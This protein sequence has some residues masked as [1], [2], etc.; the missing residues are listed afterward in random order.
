MNQSG[1]EQLLQMKF[2]APLRK[3]GVRGMF[4]RNSKV[5]MNTPLNF[6]TWESFHYAFASW[7]RRGAARS[8]FFGE[9][10]ILALCLLLPAMFPTTSNAQQ[11]IPVGDPIETY[12]RFL[13]SDSTSSQH[14]RPINHHTPQTSPAGDHPWANHSFFSPVNDHAGFSYHFYQPET[15]FTYNNHFAHGWNDGAMW[16]G[17]GV[18]YRIRSGISL[19]YKNFDLSVRP[20]FGRSLNYDFELSGMRSWPYALSEFAMPL[21]RIDNPVRFGDEPF[22]WFHPGQSSLTYSDYGFKAGISTENIWSGP[23]MHNPLILSNNAPGFF[24]FRLGTD[25]PYRTTVGDFEGKLFWGGLRESDY[26]DERDDNNLRFISG[27]IFSYTPSFAKNLTIGFQRVLYE[28]Y[29]DDGIGLSQITR[30]FQRFT[31]DRFRELQSG[32][33]LNISANND[34]QGDNAD[35]LLS[36]FGSWVEPD[37]G[38]ELY[39]EWGRNDQSNDR[40]NFFTEPI[41]TRSYVLGLNQK[42]PI[43]QRHWVTLNIEATQLENLEQDFGLQD[44]IWYEHTV[45]RQGF[46]NNGQVI[47]AGIGPGSN[48]QSVHAHYYNP[49]GMVGVSF[50]RVIHHNDRLIRHFQYIDLFHRQTYEP[51]E[52]GVLS[53]YRIAISSLSVRKLHEAEARFGLHGIAFL[54]Y[55]LELRAD[56]YRS[57]F[58]NR[59]NIFEN[60]M[61]NINLQ[62]TLR[63]N[64]PGMLR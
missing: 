61:N 24:H 10:L 48:S 36:F 15:T 21:S 14:I 51:E 46:T 26:F 11:S 43:N 35:R 62:F 23:A 20:E 33:D 55:N 38:F 53:D 64:L 27:L 32:E 28:N 40:R 8:P 5:P 13:Q 12:L 25:A 18:N 58:F 3:G 6:T 9:T 30:P 50:A 60:D 54:P 22:T 47:G 1:F 31:E 42:I 37:A 19:R 57:L 34:F 49:H 2:I 7:D 59:Y 44:P 29:P 41:H 17:R 52:E 63:Y 56:I 45:V 39:A 4:V 16:Q